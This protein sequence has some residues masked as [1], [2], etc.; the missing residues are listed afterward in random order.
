MAKTKKN[1]QMSVNRAVKRTL[2]LCAAFLMEEEGWDDDRLTDFYA[3][4]VR[5]SEAIDSHLINIQNVIEIIKDKT[6][7]EIKW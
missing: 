5:W 6:G 3:G 4:I 7:T 2:I 1:H